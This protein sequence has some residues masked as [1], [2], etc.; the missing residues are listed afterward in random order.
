[1]HQLPTILTIYTGAFA[2]DGGTTLLSA[3]DEVGKDHQVL[4]VQHAFARQNAPPQA[5][6]GRLYFDGELV[7]VRSPFEDKLIELLRN[8]NL[9]E[10]ESPESRPQARISPKALIV[11]DDIKRVV[12]GSPEQNLRAMLRGIIDYVCSDAYASFAKKI[13]EMR[14][15]AQ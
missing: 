5:I 3:T 6:P 15:R 13:D 10:M 8:A 1:M 2:T 11:G 12:Q 9:Q 4:L 7:A 14:S